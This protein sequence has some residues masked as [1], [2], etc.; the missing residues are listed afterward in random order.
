M[1]QLLG[2]ANSGSAFCDGISRRGLLNI[3]TLAAL[4]TATGWSLPSLLQ[5]EQS[6]GQGRSAKSVIMIYLVG[7]PP[8]QDMFDLKPEAPKE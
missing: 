5:A 1:L 3:G 6:A 4:G 2:P 8:H 7:G